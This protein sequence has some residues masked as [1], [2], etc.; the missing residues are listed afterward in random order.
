MKNMNNKMLL[1]YIDFT[2][3]EFEELM[4]PPRTFSKEEERLIKIKTE[5][6]VKEV[7]ASLGY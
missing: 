6:K 7:F 5:K 2:P 4:Q 1:D 3:D